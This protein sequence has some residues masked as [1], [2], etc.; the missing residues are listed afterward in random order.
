MTFEEAKT[1]KIGDKVR[2]LPRDKIVF[3]NS[4]V[5]LSTS[6]KQNE[7]YIISRIDIHENRPYPYA[8]FRTEKG[9]V[10]HEEVE[11]VVNFTIDTIYARI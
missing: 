10:Y 6:Y 3:P 5:S 1:L 7:I 4:D 11:K 9:I 8:E 2:G